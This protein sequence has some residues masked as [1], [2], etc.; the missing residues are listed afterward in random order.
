MQAVAAVLLVSLGM[1]PVEGAEA[2]VALE[3]RRMIATYDQDPA[4]LDQSRDI[5]ETALKA[6]PDGEL[7]GLLAQSCFLWGD[8][9]AKTKNEKLAAYERGREAGK[10]AVELLPRDAEAHFMY[11]VN[12]G[13]AGQMRGV[14]KSLSLLPTIKQELATIFSLQ[15]DHTGA[16][17]MAGYVDLEVPRLMGGSVDKAETHFRKAL[18]LD[19]HLTSA[20]IG[21]AN[22]MIRRKSKPEARLLLQSVLEEDRPSRKADWA[23]KDVP[24]AKK[25]L[26]D[27]K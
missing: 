21:L 13:R 6:G 9:R 19:P 15:P 3:A 10:R 14:M 17:V 7:F 5:L 20:K 23:M 11:A 24:R 22:V 8:V 2:A 4:R 27:L 26:D 18:A 12:T 16:Q 25:L 1:A